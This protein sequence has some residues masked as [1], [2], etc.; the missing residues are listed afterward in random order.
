MILIENDE[1]NETLQILR[2]KKKLPS[3][4]IELK[5]WLKERYD[6]TALN[7]IFEKM[8]YNNPENRYRLY[9][10]LSYS[11][12]QRMM[13]HKEFGYDKKKQSEI[14][15]KFFELAVKYAFNEAASVENIWVCYNDFSSEIKSEANSAAMREAGP[16]IKEKY[17][18]YPLW[19][20]Y[21]AFSSVVVFYEKDTDIKANSENG[22]SEMIKK[23]Y[24]RILKTYDE[25]SIYNIDNFIMNF[26]SK[27]N[28]DKNYEGNLYYYFK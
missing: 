3:I 16:F 14:A 20:L 5:N 11:D 12:Y 10:L 7:F 27:E 13:N 26:D 21:T 19:N 15:D 24:F 9:I 18:Q 6:I 17:K 22:L 2:G 1:Y 4:Y 25:F 8:K 28:L 23:D